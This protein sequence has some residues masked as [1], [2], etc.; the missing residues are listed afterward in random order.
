MG[1]SGT[2]LWAT[3]GK[4]RGKSHRPRI[5]GGSH[6][7]RPRGEEYD[8]PDEA[9]APTRSATHSVSSASLK[10]PESNADVC[11]SVIGRRRAHR[12]TST[13]APFVRRR[14][15]RRLSIPSRQAAIFAGH[16]KEVASA[17]A[18]CVVIPSVAGHFCIEEFEA[19]SPLPTVNLL[20]AVAAHMPGRGLRKIGVIGTRTVMASRF[21]GRLP[22]APPL[23][24]YDVLFDK[25]H[26]RGQCL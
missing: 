13:L 9:F 20:D 2:P 8:K 7:R 10:R 19:I 21:Y 24:K 22:P 12:R 16:A 11:L 18:E 1:L 23:V 17:W 4:R 15:R 5:L 14:R 6:A 26:R 3:N 25:V